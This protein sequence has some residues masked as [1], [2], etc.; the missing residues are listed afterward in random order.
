MPTI[1]CHTCQE[2][3]VGCDSVHYGSP[4]AGYRNLCGRCFNEEV[5][6]KGGVKFEHVRFGP[7]R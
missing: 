6:R 7:S 2:A 3:I 4:D 5:A 1:L